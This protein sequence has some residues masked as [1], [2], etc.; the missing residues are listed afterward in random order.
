MIYAK[1]IRKTQICDSRDEFLL[2]QNEPNCAYCVGETTVSKVKDNLCCVPLN[3]IY[4][5]LKYGEY[6][7]I[8]DI[9]D[10]KDYPTD[11]RTYFHYE[12][13]MSEQKVVKIMKAESYEAIDY[14]ADHLGDKICVMESGYPKA[15]FKDSDVLSYYYKRL[16]HRE[17]KPNADMTENSIAD[18]AQI[19]SSAKGG[20]PTRLFKKFSDR[21][22]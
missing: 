8:L 22:K 10:D 12:L 9:Q 17:H 20:L 7:A 21:L 13:S 4:C 14:V 18:N 5:C 19:Q 6:I 15:W 2:R 1:C 3:Y 16:M 11:G